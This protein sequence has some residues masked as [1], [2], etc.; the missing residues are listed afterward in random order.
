MSTRVRKTLLVVAWG[1]CLIAVYIVLGLGTPHTRIAPTAVSYLMLAVWVLSVVRTW[2]WYGDSEKAVAQR[3][4]AAERRAAR[5]PRP[6]PR[7]QQGAR[8]ERVVGVRRDTAANGNPVAPGE[9]DAE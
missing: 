7:P 8:V 9:P 3:T 5:R 6:D 2:W 4:Q 1:V